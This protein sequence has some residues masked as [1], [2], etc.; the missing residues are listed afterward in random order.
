MDV[1]HLSGIVP[2]LPTPL[3]NSG[4]IDAA[5]VAHLVRFCAEHGFD[6]AVVLGSTGE[7]P[8]FTFEEKCRVMNVAA[9]AAEGRIPVIGTAS[10]C[11]TEEAIALARAAHRAGCDAVMAAL[12]TYFKVDASTARGHFQALAAEGGLPVFFYY[13]PEVSGLVMRVREIAEIAAL[14]GVVGAKITV[15]NKAFLRE[16]IDE[17]RRHGWRVFTGTTFLFLY[18]LE[19]RGAGVFCPLP[20]VLPDEVKSISD[21]FRRGETTRAAHTQRRLLKALPLFSGVSAPVGLQVMVFRLLASLPY[22]GP[23]RRMPPTHAL[24]KEAL[25][26]TG[27][28]ITSAVRRPFPAV[29]EKQRGLV[30]RTLR[31]LGLP[32]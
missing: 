3:T 1:S 31:G 10:A 8:Y 23:G 13:F 26:I 27:H 2:I 19:T 11:G 5:G 15:V 17:T 9:E 6:G 4:E 14:E 29:D 21:D 18:C 12:P 24:L 32:G 25:R 30:R 7:F 22:R 20:L 28:P 16:V